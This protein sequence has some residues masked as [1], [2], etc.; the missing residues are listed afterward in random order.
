MGESHSLNCAGRHGSKSYR[1]NYCAGS[2][3]SYGDYLE[4]VAAF[5]VRAIIQCTIGTPDDN[6][7][8]WKEVEDIGLDT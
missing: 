5:T 4:K 7:I 8:A 1:A 3:A 2:E 6:P